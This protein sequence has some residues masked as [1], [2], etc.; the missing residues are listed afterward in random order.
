[1]RKCRAGWIAMLIALASASSATLSHADKT[2][3]EGGYITAGFPTGDWGKIAG[4]GLGLENTDVLK[5]TEK[6]FGIRSS[7]GL[8][9]N[10]SRTE[11]VPQANLAPNSQLELETKNWSLFFG[12]GPELSMPKGDV[13]PFVFG[14]AGFDTYWTKS[15][16]SGT[17]GGT[18]YSAKHGDSRI[19]FAWSAGLGLRRHLGEGILGELSAEFRSGSGHQFVL[20]D[21]VTGSGTTV[22][23]SRDTHTTN[24]II[25]RFGTLFGS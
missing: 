10:F 7:L 19:G 6:T 13:H 1:M 12:I 11:S 18:P 9:Y 14:T 4:F 23:A 15:E 3:M 16:L 24:Q 21:E 25:V 17:A 2:F 22:N 5:D 8:H 20:P